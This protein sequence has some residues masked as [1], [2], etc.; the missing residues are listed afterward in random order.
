[1]LDLP[2]TGE[3]S[4]SCFCIANRG[5]LDGAIV[6]S[7]AQENPPKQA[8]RVTHHLGHL[9]PPESRRPNPSPR[10]PPPGAVPRP[11]FGVRSGGG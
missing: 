6:I 8:P 11:W 9:P 4:Y 7:D 3:V 10:T 5:F 2:L 1:M